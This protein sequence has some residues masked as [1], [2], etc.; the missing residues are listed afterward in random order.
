[1]KRGII[2]DETIRS[3]FAAIIHEELIPALGCTEPI[4]VAYA[5]ATVREVLG[6]LPEHLLV[7]CSADIIKNVKSVVVP[8]TEDM[9]GA[10]ASAILGVIG[11]VAS[12][13]LEVLSGVRPEHLKKIRELLQSNFCEIRLLENIPGLDIVITAWYGDENALVE[14]R[15]AHTNI[16]R[17][18]K[19]GRAIFQAEDAT[20]EKTARLNYGLLNLK[21]IYD[22][23]ASEDISGI[24]PILEYQE[25]CNLNIAREGLAHPYGEQVGATLMRYYGD[26]IKNRAR[27]LAAAGSDARMSGCVLP[28]V[29]NS[30]SGNQGITV[31][32]PVLVYADYL[33]VEAEKKYRALALSNLVSIHIKHGVGKLSA[34]CGA[35]SAA[36]GS[37]AAITYLSGGDF[38]AVAR[39]VTNTLGNVTGI[40]CD[41]AKPSCAAKIASAVDA[42]ILGH[43]MAMDGKVFGAEEGIVMDDVERTISS[44]VRVA[45]KGMRATDLEILSIMIGK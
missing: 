1:M 40:I 6:S 22:F 23:C 30:G 11:G 9:R 3:Q 13:K 33:E 41:G 24:V 20:S 39:T 26:D 37:G 42:A 12:K 7:E 27:A 35:V 43:C 36:C 25:K 4:A 15:N 14:I 31:S 44:V 21:D 5:A 28:V 19:N 34:F 17:I 18:E 16:V 10:E 29:I 32:L 8:T 45:K 38:A 2:V